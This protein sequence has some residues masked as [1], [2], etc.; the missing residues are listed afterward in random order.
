M[1]VERDGECCQEGGKARA[2]HH[3]DATEVRFPVIFHEANHQNQQHQHRGD[4]GEPQHETRYRENILFKID[5][6]DGFDDVVFGRKHRNEQWR[7]ARI[8]VLFSVTAHVAHHVDRLPARSFADVVD[9][10]GALINNRTNCRPATAVVGTE[11][12]RMSI[13]RSGRHDAGRRSRQGRDNQ[14]GIN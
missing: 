1:V 14:Q 11:K 9:L 6:E 7:L 12:R 13:R 3:E 10:I 2:A 4:I 5:S 8:I